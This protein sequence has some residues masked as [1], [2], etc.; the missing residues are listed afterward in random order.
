[1]AQQRA[2]VGMLVLVGL[3][4]MFFTPPEKK[5]EVSIYIDFVDRYQKADQGVEE[6]I[7]IGGRIRG[8]EDSSAY[9]VVI[10]SETSGRYRI[11]PWVGDYTPVDSGGVWERSGVR[12]GE[13]MHVLLLRKQDKVPLKT[14]L[15]KEEFKSIPRIAEVIHSWEDHGNNK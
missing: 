6:K 8:L 5:P 15:T 12:P 4:G 2:S 13:R 10:F 7:T 14:V 11:Q 9:K 3:L 1:M